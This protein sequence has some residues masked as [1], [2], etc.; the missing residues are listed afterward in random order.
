MRKVLCSLI[1]ICLLFNIGMD[2]QCRHYVARKGLEMLKQGHDFY[3]VFGRIKEFGSQY[4]LP[5]GHVR[6]EMDG[7]VLY[8]TYDKRYIWFETKRLS[9]DSPEFMVWAKRILNEVQT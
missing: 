1:I 5:Y 9:G 4:Y 3:V 8:D 7:N 6:I 2:W